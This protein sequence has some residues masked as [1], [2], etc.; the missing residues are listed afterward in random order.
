LVGEHE[1]GDAEVDDAQPGR[2]EH[3]TEVEHGEEREEPSDELPRARRDGICD[4]PAEGAG[5]LGRGHGRA[6]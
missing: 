4:H 5:A 2:Q 1:D 6:A 3:A